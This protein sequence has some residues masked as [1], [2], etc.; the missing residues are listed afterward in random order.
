MKDGKTP[1]KTAAPDMIDEAVEE[2][3]PASDPPAWTPLQARPPA[4]ENTEGGVTMNWDRIKGQWKQL[5]GN[6][7]E[8]WG[9]LT[10]NEL[11]QIAGQRDQ[12]LGKLE[13]KYGLAKEQAERE[14]D[15]MLK[16]DEMQRS[17]KG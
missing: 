9:K 17:M 6:L 10:D 12:L 7:R 5:K 13:E 16:L 11:D 8:K 14:L 2:S 4:A 3:F 15:E 1:E